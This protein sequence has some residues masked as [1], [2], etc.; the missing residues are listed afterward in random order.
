[1]SKLIIC[2][3]GT[4]NSP[5][6]DEKGVPLA[7][8]VAKVAEAV[9]RE[10]SQGVKQLTY[11]DTGVGTAGG[12]LKRIFA[13][14]TGWGLSENLLEAYRF[15]IRN[16]QPED[17]LY[18]F[19][20]S[21]GAFTVRSLAGL[22]N[23]SGLLRPEFE[24]M[25]DQAYEL[26]RSRSEST[27]P[28]AREASLFRKTYAW[29]DRIP[30]RFIG[31]WDTVGALGNPLLL[32]K[33]PLS[34][35]FRFHDTDLSSTVE[36]AFHAMAV[37]EKRR[38]FKA[39]KWNKQG[40]SRGQVLEQRWFVGVHSNVGGGYP[41]TGL[42]DIALEWIVDKALDCGLEMA[43]IRTSPDV[44]QGPQESRKH[45][46]KLVP[47]YYRPVCPDDGGNGQTCESVDDSVI[48]RWRENEEYRPQNL[49]EYF[50]RHPEILD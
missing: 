4:W 44:M 19:G 36:N 42:S 7:T 10:D 20:F 2:C 1:M 34:S 28:R 43:E 30:V 12:K 49:Q 23:S 25:V 41:Q 11:Y 47:K 6:E 3:D 39:T 31:V 45:V 46:Y 18:L 17:L 8:N 22:V 15:L 37:D 33:S 29:A 14:S 27:H 50:E 40:K 21:R 5:D 48:R 9:P 13:G 16:Y 38:H 24:S 35:K 26:Y 32:M